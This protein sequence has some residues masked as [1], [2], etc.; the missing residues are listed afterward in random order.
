MVVYRCDSAGHLVQTYRFNEILGLDST[1]VTVNNLYVD[2]GGSLWAVL[3]RYGLTRYDA[4][5]QRFL[6]VPVDTALDFFVLLQSRDG[7]Y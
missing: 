5:Q 7:R 3:G 2:N 4:E 6:R 1:S